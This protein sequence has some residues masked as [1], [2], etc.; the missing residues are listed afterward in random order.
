MGNPM[1]LANATMSPFQWESP[2]AQSGNYNAGRSYASTQ[3]SGGNMQSQNPRWPTPG[4]IQRPSNN[5]NNG[6]G[7]PS[8]SSQFVNYQQNYPNSHYQQR[9]MRNN[10][11][12]QSMANSS[13]MSMM[14]QGKSQYFN[15]PQG[16]SK[17]K[18]NDCKL[19]DQLTSKNFHF[20]L[21]PKATRR[22]RKLPHP[23]PKHQATPKSI[24]TTQ[25][26]S[27]CVTLRIYLIV[28]R[29]EEKFD[30]NQ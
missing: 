23:P 1:P 29:K 5:T 12:N 13:G 4:P 26:R 16:G 8:S 9:P 3:S 15:Q 21:N 2:S 20:Q 11:M 18:K 14:S 30:K 17:R 24:E 10:T 27:I 22:N 6:F 25:E 19:R 28:H 7:A